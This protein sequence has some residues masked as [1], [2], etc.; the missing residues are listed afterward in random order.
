MRLL[1][2]NGPNLNL[3]GS[4]EPN[5][6]GR[7]TYESLISDLQTHA[8]K[9]GTKLD[10]FQSNHEGQLI[11]Y[12]QSAAD[13]FDGIIL[14]PGALTHYS[15]AL[16]DAI[17]SIKLPVLEVHISN[18]HTRESFRQISVTAPACIGQI[19]GLGIQGYFLAVDYFIYR[20]SQEGT[21]VEGLN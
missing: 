3:L 7:T 20:L 2:L 16:R 17:Q 18:I 12:I 8:E 6:Y 11:D 10:C 14:N 19:S 5:I 9:S 4:R 21:T 15:Y 1:L 13:V